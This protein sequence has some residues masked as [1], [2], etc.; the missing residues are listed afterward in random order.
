VEAVAFH[1]PARPALRGH[2]ASAGHLLVPQIHLRPRLLSQLTDV[3]E[4][5]AFEPEDLILVEGDARAEAVYIVFSGC[6]LV[7]QALAD[8]AEAEQESATE[9]SLG[10]PACPNT[11]LITI[12]RAGQ[13]FGARSLLTGVPRTTSVSAMTEVECLRIERDPFLHLLGGLHEFVCDKAPRDTSPSVQ[14]SSLWAP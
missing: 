13:Y 2:L 6:C 7:S 9:P 11:K 14:A 10:T 12:L 8:G 5:C 1:I 3:V 4:T